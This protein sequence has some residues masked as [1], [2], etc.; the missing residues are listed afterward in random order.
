[1][2]FLMVFIKPSLRKK[3]PPVTFNNFMQRPEMLLKITSFSGLMLLLLFGGLFVG[4]YTASGGAAQRGVEKESPFHRMLREYD[5]KYRRSSQTESSAVQRQEL[6]GLDNDLDRLEKKAEGVESWLS[7]LKRRRQLAARDSHYEQS[8]QRSSRRAALAFPFSEPI[9][10]VAAAALVHNVAI[11]E[12]A[13]AQLRNFLPLL[14]SPRFVPMRFSLHVLLGDLRTPQR[15]MANMTDIA[16]LT[17]GQLFDPATPKVPPQ[18][19]SKVPPLAAPLVQAVAVDLAIM[20]ILAGNLSAAADIQTALTAFPSPALIRLA[21]EYFFDFG[22]LIRSA[23]LF[24]MLPDETALS[25]QADA[26]W[27]AGYT[28]N[29]RTIWAMLASSNPNDS[30]LQNRA[31]LQSKVALQSKALYNLALTAKTREEAA[32]LLERLLRQAATWQLP[33][34]DPG[35]RYGLIRFS[36][37]LEPQ[38]ASA[39]LEA[40]RD[41]ADMLIDLEILK[42]R[43]EIEETARII[44]ETWQIGRAHV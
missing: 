5:F 6:E 13:G 35:Y 27:L 11:T 18:V 3:G 28:E 40:E 39:L 36:R 16:R 1:M 9:A 7:V 10:A 22:D 15:A 37:L 23:E 24:S 31:A 19:P 25:Q 8:Y 26:L 41:S 44:A 2:G 33:A 42:R 20:K 14:A 4:A 29:A 43:S 17:Q 32:A 30:A 38:K 34:G 12:E 21:A